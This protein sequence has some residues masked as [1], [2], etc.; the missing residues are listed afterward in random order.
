[1][2][3]WIIKWN[4]YIISKVQI[5]TLTMLIS[6]MALDGVGL[7]NT[8]HMPVKGVSRPFVTNSLGLV[9]LTGR[10]PEGPSRRCSTGKEKKKGYYMLLW[11]KHHGNC[12]THLPP[13][14]AYMRQ[15]IRSALVQIMAC[16]LFGTKPLSEP[17]LVCCQL[18]S[19]EQFSIKFESEFYHFHSR[20][21]IQSCRL[22]KMA[23][24]MSR[25]RVNTNLSNDFLPDSTYYGNQYWLLV[26]RNIS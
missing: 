17:M 4:K 16:R 15:W 9:A 11:N 25:G 7:V 24:N 22:P 8:R 3:K 5:L 26:Q 2:I 6:V 19:W 10:L 13:C 23:A 12:L 20:K 14:A 18:D 1:M 21:C